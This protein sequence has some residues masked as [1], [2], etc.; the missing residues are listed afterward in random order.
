MVFIGGIERSGNGYGA[1]A[2]E[3]R[4]VLVSWVG[5]V[6]GALWNASE[7]GPG[8]VASAS[9]FADSNQFLY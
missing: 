6:V 3:R 4:S 2:V 1:L 5:I 7:N 9:D 8:L